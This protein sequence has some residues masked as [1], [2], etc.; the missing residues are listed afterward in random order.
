MKAMET[1]SPLEGPHLFPSKVFT[2]EA[3][4]TMLLIT[5]FTASH[6]PLQIFSWWVFRNMM[7]CIV[8]F[9]CGTRGGISDRSN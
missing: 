3:V 7:L 6:V 8:I 9:N 1:S 2:F 4:S 5:F